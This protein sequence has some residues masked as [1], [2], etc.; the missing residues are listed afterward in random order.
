MSVSSSV[1]LI[2]HASILKPSAGSVPPLGAA[3]RGH[4]PKP[5]L[6]TCGQSA[7]RNCFIP[8]PL[9]SFLL[10]LVRPKLFTGLESSRAQKSRAEVGRV[11][12]RERTWDHRWRGGGEGQR[13]EE[14]EEETRGRFLAKFSLSRKELSGAAEAG[15][16]GM[17][18]ESEASAQFICVP[19]SLTL[20]MH[21]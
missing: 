12:K 3:R 4:E 6:S 8:S 15:G 14:E 9:F 5:L 21:L 17:Q 7:G 11:L 2:F 20:L 18:L 19:Q 16:P 1:P 13:G 10:P